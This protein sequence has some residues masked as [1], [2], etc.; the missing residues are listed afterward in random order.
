MAEKA[1]RAIGEGARDSDR[2]ITR[3]IS[4]RLAD[5]QAVVQLAT[6]PQ[7]A[8]FGRLT[9]LSGGGCCV[10]LRG[11]EAGRFFPGDE[12]TVSMRLEQEELLYPASV[13]GV[14]RRHDTPNEARLRLRF[15]KADLVTQQR[16]IRWI[17]HLSVQS[18]HG[19]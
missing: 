8:S 7:T 15:A 4:L 6:E 10:V 9:N 12:C 5:A 2:R 17:Q 19:A 11:T 3:R 1:I 13:V 16:L 14:E 18:W